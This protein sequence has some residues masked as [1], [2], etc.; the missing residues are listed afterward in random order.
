LAMAEPPF[1]L[2][3]FVFAERIAEKQGLE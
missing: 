3:F 2:G 1:L